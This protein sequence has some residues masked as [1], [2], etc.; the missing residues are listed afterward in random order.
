[1][2]SSRSRW[3]CWRRRNC[4]AS[5]PTCRRRPGR[6]SQGAPFR[7]PAAG[8]SLGRR[9]PCLRAPAFFF[10]QGLSYAQ[11]MANHPQTLYG[12]ADSPV[13]LAAYFLDHD[14]LSYELIARVFDGQRAG[15]TRDDVLDNVTITW[16]TNTAMSGGSS[17]S[18][19]QASVFRC[20]GRL[21]P[22]CRE[23]L[24]RRALSSPAELGGAGVSQTDPLQ[25]GRQ[26][27]ALRGLGTAAALLQKRFVPA[28]DRC[29]NSRGRQSALGDGTALQHVVPASRRAT[30]V[31]ELLDQF[32]RGTDACSRNNSTIA[33]VSLGWPPF[34]WL[35]RG[36]AREIR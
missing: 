16:L 15:L 31:H 3:A 17:L 23:R 26:G 9:K 11:Q 1:M 34:R 13:G 24:S 18:G 21:H 28:S 32:F 10:T 29:A 22:G 30:R 20:R 2:P 8:R 7:A 6:H 19:E 5:T 35:R 33:A 36:S 4:S 27:R 12:I 25:Q 14:A